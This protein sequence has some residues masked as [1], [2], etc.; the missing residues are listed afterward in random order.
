MTTNGDLRALEEELRRQD[1][2]LERLRAL[3]D[4][5]DGVSLQ[6]GEEIRERIGAVVE[7]M[8]AKT[9]A[10]PPQRGIAV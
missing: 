2:E 3:A 9:I 7:Q 5:N 10:K 6:L 1:E 4:A 8:Q